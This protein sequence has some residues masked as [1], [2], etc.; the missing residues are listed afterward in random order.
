[1]SL[2]RKLKDLAPWIRRAEDQDLTLA[3]EDARGVTSWLWLERLLQDTRYALRS[4]A[5]HKAFTALVVASLALGIG[6]NTAIYSVMDGILLRPL[7]V[8]DPR[9][10]VV[11]KWRAKSY[12]LATSGMSW[13]TNGST[14]DQ[15]TGTLSSIFPYAALQ[16]FEEADDVIASALGYVSANRIA[17]SVGGE[18][19]PVKGQYVSGRYFAGIGVA[20][21]AGRLIQEEDDVVS[22]ASV[23]VLSER[24]SRRFG[25]PQAA[26]GQTV[27]IDDKPFVV[28]GVVPSAFFSAG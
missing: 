7:P 19:Q 26:V 11:M 15:A 27:R 5:H 8:R 2:W 18:T 20:A 13:S 1:M 23:A 28:I 10:L 17:L 22:V 21:V 12:T 9:S 4:M 24:Y 25:S 6:A 3:A 14:F 16:T